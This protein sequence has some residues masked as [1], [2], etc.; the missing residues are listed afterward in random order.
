MPSLC[1]KP[2]S[3]ESIDLELSPTSTPNP[4]ATITVTPACLLVP[5][6]LYPKRGWVPCCGFHHYFT[7]SPL[8]GYGIVFLEIFLRARMRSW[9]PPAHGLVQISDQQWLWRLQMNRE[10]WLVKTHATKT[11]GANSRAS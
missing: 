7:M 1:P 11:G 6:L 5:E 2:L 8:L 3:V 10:M 9:L 4:E